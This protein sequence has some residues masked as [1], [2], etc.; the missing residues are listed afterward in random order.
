M[1]KLSRRTGSVP[2][3]QFLFLGAGVGQGE[4]PR[5][6]RGQADARTKSGHDISKEN[7]HLR[8]NETGPRQRAAPIPKA[9]TGETQPSRSPWALGFRCRDLSVVCLGPRLG[10]GS[11]ILSELEGLN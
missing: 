6:L 9:D 8:C 7:I 11:S 3:S 4:K 10:S 5:G 1:F 2:V